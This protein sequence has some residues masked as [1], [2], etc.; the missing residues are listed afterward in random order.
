MMV[1]VFAMIYFL[2]QQDDFTVLQEQYHDL[3]VIFM[4]EKDM[5]KEMRVSEFV[6]CIMI[7]SLYL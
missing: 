5:N 2:S 7:L 4:T 6:P 1:S 3:V